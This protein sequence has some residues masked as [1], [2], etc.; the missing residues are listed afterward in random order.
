[1]SSKSKTP[2]TKAGG[3]GRYTTPSK[4]KAAIDD[5]GFVRSK[6]AIM[7]EAEE[8]KESKR[9]MRKTVPLDFVFENPLDGKLWDTKFMTKLRSDYQ[10]TTYFDRTSYCQYG[11]DY[12]KH[13]GFLSS[14]PAMNLVAPCRKD[15]PCRWMERDGQHP[16]AVLGTSQ[17]Q[18]NSI[19]APL[20]DAEIN[21]WIRRTPKATKRL[22]IDVF[23]G[24]GSV[25][26]AV[27]AR[28][29]GIHVYSNEWVRGRGQSIELDMRR[30]DMTTL[31]MFA[32][33]KTFRDADGHLDPPMEG[34]GLVADMIKWLK[35]QSVAVLIHVSTPCETYSA[36]SGGYHR[37]RGDVTPLT[38]KARDHD[39]MNAKLVTWFRTH[40]L[41]VEMPPPVPAPPLPSVP[42]AQARLPRPS[43]AVPPPAPPPVAPP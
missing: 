36:A 35:N 12:R 33:Q 32:L 41:E 2:E 19:P 9:A 7:R 37:P 3:S 26:E 10:Y 6:R 40:V 16:H 29:E 17:A 8:E 39:T 20:V 23:A 13:T 27:K 30:F 25:D 43:R 22:F 11:F 21:A 31:L 34:D 14:L 28:P 24:F 18:R 38:L 42:P 4:G 15:N 5:T 1:M